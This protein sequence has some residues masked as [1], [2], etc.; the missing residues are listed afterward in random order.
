LRA[1]EG[2]KAAMRLP[3]KGRN[4]MSASVMPQCP[5]RRN[6]LPVPNRHVAQQPTSNSS[7]LTR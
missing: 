5:A 7:T 4:T 6:W 3:M 2:R 1:L